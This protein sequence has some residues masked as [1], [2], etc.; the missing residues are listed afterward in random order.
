MQTKERIR[1][2]IL[3]KL[4]N[5]KPEKRFQKSKTIKEKLFLLKEFKEAKNLICY[6]SL[7]EEVD[8]F[9]IIKE[10]L[11]SGKRIFAPVIDGDQL[12]I[13]EI[14]DL[15]KDL[16]KGPLGVLQPNKKEQ[17]RE[18]IDLVIIPGLAFDKNRARLGRGKAYFDT[19]L[20][21]LSKSVK[22]VG[23][24]YDFQVLKSIPVTPHDI[25]VDIVITN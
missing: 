12:G 13:S 25:P 23:L 10:A 19:F 24:A 11:K 3:E 7:K 15:D 9:G 21:D 4:R 8:T 14:K 20:K 17:I 16:Q 2:E 1:K 22:T 18:K 6:V 5:Q